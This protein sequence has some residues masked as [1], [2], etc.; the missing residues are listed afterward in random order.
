[1]EASLDLICEQERWYDWLPLNRQA[2]CARFWYRYSCLGGKLPIEV[3]DIVNTTVRE[4]EQTGFELRLFMGTIYLIGQEWV[5]DIDISKTVH[6]MV[7]DDATLLISEEYDEN[8]FHIL[9]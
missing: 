4:Y 8:S 7:A 6:D 2:A 3:M 1:M 9:L 5:D